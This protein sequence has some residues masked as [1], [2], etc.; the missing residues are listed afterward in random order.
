MI[1]KQKSSQSMRPPLRKRKTLK[2][3][4][5]ISKANRNGKKT[6]KVSLDDQDGGMFFGA[7]KIER[8]GGNY[9]Y[10]PLFRSKKT[11]AIGQKL[12]DIV[13][14]SLDSDKTFYNQGRVNHLIS[15]LKEGGDF[16]SKSF[17]NGDLNPIPRSFKNDPNLDLFNLY[18][19]KYIIGN[20]IPKKPIVKG[21][22]VVDK[23]VKLKF[24]REIFEENV[25]N[26]AME[27]PDKE[28]KE[29]DDKKKKKGN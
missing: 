16:F 6:L 17:F 5:Q 18:L 8:A 23:I 19:I 26:Q 4:N 13:D 20:V 22:T 21:Y 3:K 7:R 28:K 12:F 10:R 11:G 15:L 25:A 9:P 27:T 2:R 1:I 24:F 29:I 14:I